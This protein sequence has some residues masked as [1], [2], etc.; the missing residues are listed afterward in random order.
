MGAKRLIGS[1]PGIC[2]GNG[3]ICSGYKQEEQE[4][5]QLVSRNTD[6]EPEEEELQLGSSVGGRHYADCANYRLSAAQVIAFKA[7]TQSLLEVADG[8][9]PGAESLQ[10]GSSVRPK[11]AVS[12]T[13]AALPACAQFPQRQ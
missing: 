4:E 12:K 3:V 1:V 10:L 5:L 8:A 11:D 2:R 6:E 13:C 7:A 9:A